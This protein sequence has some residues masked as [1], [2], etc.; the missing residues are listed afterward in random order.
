MLPA[1][2]DVI[3]LP[4]H[5]LARG[6]APEA[7]HDQ[8]PEEEGRMPRGEARLRLRRDLEYHAD[9]VRAAR[10]RASPQEPLAHLAQLP[11]S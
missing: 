4:H 6:V 7:V 8:R 11:R 1:C 5:S 3:N 10:A 2:E 9:V